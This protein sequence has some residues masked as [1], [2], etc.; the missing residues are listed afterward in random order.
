M[1]FGSVLA[2]QPPTTLRPAAGSSSAVPPSTVN[3]DTAASIDTTVNADTVADTTHPTRLH[4]YNTTSANATTRDQFG[5]AS[6]APQW[7]NDPQAT[8]HTPVQPCAGSS[9][10]S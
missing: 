7:P 6:Q 5:P 4:E 2:T 9:P 1:S 3:A 8:G 10:L